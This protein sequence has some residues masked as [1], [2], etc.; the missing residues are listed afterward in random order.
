MTSL[1]SNDSVIGKLWKQFSQFF[2]ESTKPTAKHLF[3]LA[4]SVLALNGF[5]SIKYNFEHFIQ[6]ISDHKLKSFYFSLNESKIDLRDWMG[7]LIAS[8]LSLLPRNCAQALVL[9]IDDTLIEK[10]GEKFAYK[11]KLFDHASHNGS[12]YLN[13]HCFVSLLLSTPVRDPSGSRYL[14]FPVAY[15]MWTKVQSKLEIA[16]D[17]VQS[18]M[19]YL[20]TQRQIILCCD[21]WYPKGCVKELVKAYANLVMICNVRT[22][23]AIYALPPAHTGKKGRPKVRGKRLSLDDFELKEVAGSDLLVGFRAV[24]TMLFGSL[25]VYAVVTKRANGKAYRL[26]LC[27]K[28]PKDL[29]FDISFLDEDA[30]AFAAAD[31]NYLPLSIY[32]LRWNIEVAYYEQKSFWAL[33]DYRLRS[34]SG[35]ERL[36]NLLTL[37][38]AAVKLLPYLSEDFCALRGA[39][40]QQARFAFGRSI[41]QEV[42][43]TSFVVRLEGSIKSAKFLALL[44]SQFLSMSAVAFLCPLLHRTCNIAAALLYGFLIK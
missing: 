1:Y 19:T 44:R 4:L 43:F 14:S 24:K 8:A 42:F 41:C 12:N 27:T 36:V 31:M 20:G 39:S 6:D 10:Y 21:S 37:V 9:S 11:S 5:Y 29:H 38:Y 23:T 25:T 2:S 7:Q 35:I 32:A 26:F 33:G 18:A 22:D 16:R 30:A 3:E 13:G 34:Q 28:D 40:P 17:L 15:R